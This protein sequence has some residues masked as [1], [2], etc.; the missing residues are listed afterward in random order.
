M[1]AQYTSSARP[2]IKSAER[3]WPVG[4]AT[5]IRPAPSF[6][7]AAIAVRSV[8]PA[9]IPSSTRIAGWSAS[10]GIGR[11]PRSC[12]TRRATFSRAAATLRSTSSAE[13]AKR[14]RSTSLIHSVPSNATAPKPDSVV[15][16]RRIL[17]TTA[18][19]SGSARRRAISAATGTPPA[20]IASTIASLARNTGASIVAS[21]SPACPRLRKT[22]AR[23]RSAGSSW[24]AAALRLVPED[25]GVRL[26]G[27]LEEV[28]ER[29]SALAER[30]L[31]LLLVVARLGGLSGLGRQCA[32]R[33][34]Q[35]CE[36]PRDVLRDDRAR[37]GSAVT[38]H[39]EELHGDV[40]EHREA[41]DVAVEFHEHGADCKPATVESRPSA[42]VR[43]SGAPFAARPTVQG[44]AARAGPRR[45]S[46][47]AAV[48]RA[49]ERGGPRARRRDRKSTR[50]NSSHL[51][52]SYA[53]FC[54]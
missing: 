38:H 35:A 19:S 45:R 40:A 5:T 7:S 6:R 39:L 48:R 42:S 22:G 29:I 28:D 9:A 2:A 47:R 33:R 15:H 26:H 51:G 52:I 44:V 21:A 54:L 24:M 17:L 32:E 41:A 46:P 12:A 20:G 25:V 23:S 3:S 27:A 1:F 11:A 49:H 34:L 18:R 13:S 50:L 43:R 8:D 53:V 10:A 14:V 30:H 16:G 4:T 31:R 36:R 37:D